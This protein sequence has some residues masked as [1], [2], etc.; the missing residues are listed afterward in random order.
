MADPVR[1]GVIAPTSQV[2][3]LAVTPAIVRS[4]AC[5]LVAAAS[6]SAPDGGGWVPAGTRMYPDYDQLIDDPEVEA[7]YIPLPNSMHRAWAE[8]AAAAG[9]HVLCEKPL[10]PNP[11]DAAAMSSAAD[12]AGVV[13]ME[14]YMSPFHPR[15]RAVQELVASGVLGRILFGFAAF[16]GVLERPDDHRWWPEMG[17]GSLLDVGIYCV[18]PLLSAAGLTGEAV[19]SVRVL[20]AVAR[21]AEHGVDA[22]FGALLDLGS[23]RSASFQCSFEAPE[24]QI[25]EIVGEQATISVDRAFTPGPEDTEIVLRRRDGTVETLVSETCDPY[26]AMVEHFAS[27]IRGTVALERPASESVALA[28]LLERLAVAGRR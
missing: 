18:A 11:T 19:D 21:R 4:S 16:T 17:G 27:V 15:A 13:L 8:R 1:F 9:K 2:A 12:S 14:A 5:R 7:V 28:R 26:F 24:R 3:R 22:S 25:V 23:G 6:H 10:A 20:G